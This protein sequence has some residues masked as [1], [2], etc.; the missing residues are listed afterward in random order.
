MG[1]NK[2]ILKLIKIQTSLS[3]LPSITNLTLGYW[4]YGELPK[5]KIF[6]KFINDIKQNKIFKR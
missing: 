4:K 6:K 5:L 1:I 3:Y 2:K